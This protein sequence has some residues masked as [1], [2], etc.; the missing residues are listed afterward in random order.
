MHAY[1]SVSLSFFNL[2][3]TTHD[4][5]QRANLKDLKR[6]HLGFVCFKVK[7]LLWIEKNS[8]TKS[9]F[10]HYSFIQFFSTESTPSITN[11][12]WFA[13]FNTF[14]KHPFELWPFCF[15]LIITLKK[16][17]NYY[18]IARAGSNSYNKFLWS[19][20]DLQRYKFFYSFDNLVLARFLFLIFDCIR[21]NRT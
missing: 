7:G 9:K 5:F 19:I 10:V 14:E 18:F 11:S 6:Q 4:L 2:Y 20:P 8:K 13:S 15:N 21:T 1:K 16:M 3:H 17:K 12:Y